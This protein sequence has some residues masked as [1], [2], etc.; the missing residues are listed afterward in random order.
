MVSM[1]SHWTEAFNC[2]QATPSSVAKA[3]LEKSTPIWKMPFGPHIDQQTHITGQ[4]TLRSHHCLV[5][6]YFHCTYYIQSSGLVKHSN[7]IIKT[8]LEKFIEV[9]QIVWSKALL[10]ILLNLTS[11]P[12][13]T[14]KLSPFEIVTGHWKHLDPASFHQKLIKEEILLYCK[15]LIS[16][17]KIT[18]FW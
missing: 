13:G 15:G 12:L 8:H 9:L 10:L 14:R 4:V 18:M 7:S 2:R 5:L 16:W 1:F 11:I 17:S 3:L 6:Q